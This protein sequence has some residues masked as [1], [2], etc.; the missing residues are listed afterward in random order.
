[1]WLKYF[2]IPQSE[3]MSLLFRIPAPL[4]SVCQLLLMIIGFSFL[5]INSLILKKLKT[6]EFRRTFD[7]VYVEGTCESS[8]DD[9]LPDTEAL[10]QECK[11]EWIG[12]D[13][14]G[15]ICDTHEDCI[16]IYGGPHAENP[17][18]DLSVRRCVG[19]R[20]AMEIGFLECLVT[21]MDSVT[22]SAIFTQIQRLTENATAPTTEIL[23]N[24]LLENETCV[25]DYG[26]MHPRRSHF[27]ASSL[28]DMSRQL[29]LSVF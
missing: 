8:T 2:P 17:R 23:Y 16:D 11:T 24:L 5:T 28:N 10:M 26:P 18:C 9:F 4:H 21:K 20:K 3:Q 13:A 6:Y 25:S 1:M 14:S 27:H 7:Q 22:R 15:M 12:D 29:C 19:V